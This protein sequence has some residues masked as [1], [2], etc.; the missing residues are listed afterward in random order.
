[1]LNAFGDP[2]VMSSNLTGVLIDHLRKE[3]KGTGT[4]VLRDFLPV[5]ERSI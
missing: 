3:E 4:G 1:M 5:L 2:A